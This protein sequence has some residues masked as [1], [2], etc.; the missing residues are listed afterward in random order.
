M[1]FKRNLF[2]RC[3]ISTDE[4]TFDVVYYLTSSVG[5]RPEQ[6]GIELVKEPAGEGCNIENIS[7]KIEEMTSLLQ[8]LKEGQVTPMTA[9]D[10]VSDWLVWQDQPI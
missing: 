5:R 4:G 10:I 3:S 2:G 8:L 6:Y 1:Y 9:Y 7:T